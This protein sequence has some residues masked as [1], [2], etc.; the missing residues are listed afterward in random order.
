MSSS[1]GIQHNFH[2]EE[3]KYG[4]LKRPHRI[5]Q[6]PLGLI[7]KTVLNFKLLRKFL[8]LKIYDFKNISDDKICAKQTAE[9]LL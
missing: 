6:L 8:S 9:E 5:T 4:E 1:T 7:L 3:I 2:T